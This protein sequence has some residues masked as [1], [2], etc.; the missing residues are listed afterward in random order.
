MY[1]HSLSVCGSESVTGREKRT[2]IEMESQCLADLHTDFSDDL[3]QWFSHFLEQI[4][5]LI[6]SDQI[7]TQEVY[8]SVLLI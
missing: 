1:Q 6:K 4:S 5:G 7:N 2:H 3:G 8:P